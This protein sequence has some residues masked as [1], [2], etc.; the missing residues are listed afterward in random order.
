MIIS[1]SSIETM[2]KRQSI[3]TFERRNISESHYAA[4]KDYL[5]NEENLI[6]P[7]GGKGNIQLV[8][9]TNNVTDK[10]IRLGTYGFIRN[11]RAYLVGVAQNNKESLLDFAYT[12]QKLVLFLTDLGIGTCWMGGTFNRYSFEREISINKG[13]FIP[14]VTPI[15]Y[16]SNYQRFFDVALRYA[17]KADNKKP[18]NRLFYNSDFTQILTKEQAGLFETPIEMVRLG[19]SASNKQPWR[20]ILSPD[21]KACH[22]YIHHTPNYS[23]ALG[24]DMQL[25]DMGIAM[26]QFE[27][28]CD[29]LHLE[30]HW[31]MED[32]L[33]ELPNRLTEYVVSWHLG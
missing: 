2:K 22:F 4:I 14:A 1:K 8:Q 9:I 27:M 16:P 7:F 19:P 29:E 20:L 23:T 18:W 32:P 15:G 26:C 31:K 3:R 21:R 24:Y 17:V 13:E 5:H 6:G 30:G 10:G 33:I 25:L 11:P 12:F 28:A